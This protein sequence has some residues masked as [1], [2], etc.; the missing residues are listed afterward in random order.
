MRT[1]LDLPDPLF[2]HLKTRAALEGRTLR[3]L[4]IELVEKGLTARNTVNMQQRFQARPVVGASAT[5]PPSAEALTNAKLFEL[6][7]RDDDERAKHILQS[8]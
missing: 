8:R 4:V 1:T 7:N 3:E 2:K 5:M 6:I